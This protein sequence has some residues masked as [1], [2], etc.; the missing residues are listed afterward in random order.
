MLEHSVDY[1]PEQTFPVEVS[2][3]E[4]TR[5][6]GE[7]V[8]VRMYLP[9]GP[10]P[11]PALLDVHGGAWNGGARTANAVIDQALAESGV[12]VAAIDFRLAPRY[13]Y[14]AA[15]QDV[16]YGT[17][18]LKAHC[19]DFNADPATV[20][21]LGGSSGGHLVALSAIRPL[22]PRYSA[23]PLPDAAHVGASVAYIISCWGV[24]DPL[25]RYRYAQEGRPDLVARTKAFF[26]TE[27]NMREGNPTLVLER[28]VATHLP[29]AL[30]IQGT[31]D[32]NVPNAIA[33]RFAAAYRAAGGQ[34]ELEWFP[35]MPHGF[36][37]RPGPQATRAHELIKAFIA[38]QLT[39]NRS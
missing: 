18:W 35:N 4:Y 25:A 39:S 17:R 11:F 29:P 9:Q 13:P 27:E 19:G 7:P 38:R 30:V 36:A 5:F 22:D 33:E 16:N 21:A 26:L 24:L 3:L 34:V 6:E 12:V 23:L 32:D 28:G 37:N 10:G 20:G 2:D 14:P 15:V 8:L 1:R 31:T